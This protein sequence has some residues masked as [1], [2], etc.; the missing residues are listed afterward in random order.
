MACG[1]VC[2]RAAFFFKSNS[3]PSPTYRLGHGRRVKPFPLAVQCPVERTQEDAGIC[4]RRGR[5]GRGCGGRHGLLPVWVGGWAGGL[6]GRVREDVDA[7]AGLRK[8]DSGTRIRATALL[9][10]EGTGGGGGGLPD[11]ARVVNALAR[12]PR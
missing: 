2:V 3:I 12:L 9:E 6:G 11:A 4:C 10:V 8:G 7:K 5:R 1:R